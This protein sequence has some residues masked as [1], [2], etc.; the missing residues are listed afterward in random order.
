[1]KSALFIVTSPLQ[2]LCAAEAFK[3]YKIGKATLVVKYGGND[4][5]N[6]MLRD[7]LL[8][9]P[10]WNA[11]YIITK[12]KS[13]RETYKTV[14]ALRGEKYNLVLNAEFNA[15]FQNI[16]IA[17]IK[18]NKRVIFDDGVMTLNDYRVYFEPRIASSKS[19]LE[20]ELLLRVLGI[21]KFRPNQ[22][23]EIE[24]F[25]MF[26]LSPTPHVSVVEN[27]FS[28]TTYYRKKIT[29]DSNAPTGILGQPLV[30]AGIVSED[31]YLKCLQ[32]LSKNGKAYYFP[33][34]AESKENIQKWLS[35][36]N[37]KLIEDDRP[38]EISITS[39]KVSSIVGFISTA[40]KTLSLLYPKL[41]IQ[42][43][44]TPDDE[45]LTEKFRINA[46]NTYAQYKGEKVS[47]IKL[48][49]H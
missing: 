33:H 48:D 11:T 34:R 49:I 45:F 23:D 24:L 4:V 8:E 6:N 31:Y 47:E 35:L 12:E 17:N 46:R 39:Y 32:K 38:I 37:L 18:Y 25:T 42:F 36:A 3:Y 7:M 20:K 5:S 9:Y 16:L 22:F 1:M 43:I 10:L 27:R 19:H 2:L 26:D 15:W 41:N 21:S 28:Q 13:L 30:E 40:L 14:R 44:R 29:S